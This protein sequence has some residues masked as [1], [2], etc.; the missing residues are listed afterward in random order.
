MY[1]RLIIPIMV[2]RTG[3]FE[4]WIR[5]PTKDNIGGMIA[6]IHISLVFKKKLMDVFTVAT[7]KPIYNNHNVII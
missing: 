1:V 4:V 2:P 7:A 5:Y 3:I 6:R